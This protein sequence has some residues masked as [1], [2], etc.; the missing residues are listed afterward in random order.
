LLLQPSV[1]V[2][3]L[4]YHAWEFEKCKEWLSSAAARRELANSNQAGV[5]NVKLHALAHQKMMVAL[6]PPPMMGAPA[7]GPPPAPPNPNVAP[8]APTM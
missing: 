7:G 3:E 4:D 2:D 8:P 1:P 5:L 6:A